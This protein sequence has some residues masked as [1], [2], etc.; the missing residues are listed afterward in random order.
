MIKLSIKDKFNSYLDNFKDI[1]RKINQLRNLEKCYGS[2]IMT[3]DLSINP[4][5]A[6]ARERI[7]QDYVKYCW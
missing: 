5:P 2:L 3:V 7:Y 1:F 6:I 4:D